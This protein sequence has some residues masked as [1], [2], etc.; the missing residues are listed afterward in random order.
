MTKKLRSLALG[1]A[2]LLALGCQAASISL[3]DDRGTT[4]TLPESPK[5]IVSLLPSLTE[6]VCELGDCAR[7]VGTDRFSN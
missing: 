5:R 1:S 7:L 4:V 6:T 2:L 3:K